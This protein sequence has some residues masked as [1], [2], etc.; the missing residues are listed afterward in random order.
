MHTPEPLNAAEILMN[1]M[2]RMK[3]SLILSYDPRNDNLFYPEIRDRSLHDIFQRI[4][5]LEY[6]EKLFDIDCDIINI[7][8]EHMRLVLSLKSSK[9]IT[10][11]IAVFCFPER[12]TG[13]TI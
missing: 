5:W 1:I 11:M 8:T 6:R 7:D 9:F 3:E 2:Q 12:K 13:T 10:S 4:F